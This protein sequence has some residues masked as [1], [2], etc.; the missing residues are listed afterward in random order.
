MELGST[1]QWERVPYNYISSNME[2]P[3]GFHN[4][5]AKVKFHISSKY[6]SIWNWVVGKGSIYPVTLLYVGTTIWVP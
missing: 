2:L 1:K 5:V 4:V 6:A 3:Y